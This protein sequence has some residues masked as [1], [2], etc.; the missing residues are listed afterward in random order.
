MK[1]DLNS[2][3]LVFVLKWVMRIHHIILFAVSMSDVFSNK[4]LKKI[5]K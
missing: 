1:I 5:I 3:I 4:I 2:K